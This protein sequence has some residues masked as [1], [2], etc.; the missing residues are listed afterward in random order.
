MRKYGSSKDAFFAVGIELFS[1]HGYENLRISHLCEA[2]SASNGSFFHHF[3]S[4]Q[5]FAGELYLNV[6]AQ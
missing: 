4:K 1:V 6:L 5:R 2:A 3:G